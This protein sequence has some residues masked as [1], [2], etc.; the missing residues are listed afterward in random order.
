MLIFA[1]DDEP[2]SLRVLRKAIAKAEPDAEILDYSLGSEAIRAIEERGLRPQVVFSDIQ[3]PELD[4]LRLAVRLKKASPDT[5]LV[6][7][8]G[9]S[10]YALDAIRLHVGGYIMKPVDAEQVREELLYN[11]PEPT[12][13]PDRLQVQCFGYFEVFWQGKPLNFGRRQTKELLAFLIDRQGAICMAEEIAAALWEDELDMSAAKHRLRQLISDLRG[14]LS[15]IGME[16][17]LV[18][19]V[20]RVG[21]LRN[22]M[23]CDYYRMLEGDM[24]AVNRF[25]GEYMSQYS[26]AELTEGKLRF[27]KVSE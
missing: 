25:R 24:D 12:A 26:W 11:A 1:I 8:T 16:E 7:V 9:Y 21:I 20:G 15:A 19:G 10:E 22:R 27:L 14:T 13:S 5:R 3:M 6:F 4:G 18:R 17:A 23:D 2:R